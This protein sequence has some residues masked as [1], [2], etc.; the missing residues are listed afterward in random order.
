MCFDF[1]TN[2]DITSYR[3]KIQCVRHASSES[4]NERKSFTEEQKKLL[5]EYGLVVLNAI[6]TIVE[7]S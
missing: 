3:H 1:I 4:M 6:H 7:R 2:D 5:I